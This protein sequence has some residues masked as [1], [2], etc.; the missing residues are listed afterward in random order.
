MNERGSIDLFNWVSH[1]YGLLPFSSLLFF[2][3]H[4]AGDAAQSQMSLFKC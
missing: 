3:L 2:F 1:D 4:E